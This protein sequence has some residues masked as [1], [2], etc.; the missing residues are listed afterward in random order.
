MEVGTWSSKKHVYSISAPERTASAQ[1][2]SDAKDKIIV[3]VCLLSVTVQRQ[4]DWTLWSCQVKPD[5]FFFVCVSAHLDAKKAG[6]LSTLFDVGGIVGRFFC[7][8][9]TFH[10]EKCIVIHCA[11]FSCSRFC[12]ERCPYLNLAHNHLDAL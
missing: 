8:T 10:F 6:D 5:F 11:A 1:S 9:S 7:F 2:T 12:T 4:I 3:P